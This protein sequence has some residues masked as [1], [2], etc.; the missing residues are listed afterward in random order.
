MNAVI[1]DARS[2]DAYD[3]GH[4]EGAI[5]ADLETHLS[6]KGDPAQGGRHPLPPVERWLRQVAEWG[7]TPATRVLVYDD[8]NGANAAARV[9]WMFKAIGHEN[10]EV[11][12][13]WSAGSLPA[14]PPAAG[15][16]GEA[17]GG[18]AAQR[19]ALQWQ[20]PTVTMEQV[21]HLRNDPSWRVLDVRSR[22]RFRGE[23]EPIDPV[24]GH[25]PGAVNL[26]YT[27]NVGKSPAELRAMYEQLLG[28]VPP[29]RLIVHCGSGVT[30]CHTLL[31]LD[32]A[33]LHGASLYVGSWGEWCRNGKPIGKQSR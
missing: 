6:E 3:A 24:A 13:Q 33:G 26:P 4:L 32:Q 5:H 20:L 8:A 15:R 18:P 22:E 9:W 10:V 16:A 7:I 23:T 11:L 14:G 1:L 29:E 25:I 31:A 12:P 27:D 30:A 28:E 2:R 17:A 19:A 21:D